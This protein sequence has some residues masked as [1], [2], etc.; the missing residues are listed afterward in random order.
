MYKIVG[1]RHPRNGGADVIVSGMPNL[2]AALVQGYGM[3]QQYDRLEV[4]DTASGAW[5][6]FP[7]EE[8]KRHADS[9]FVIAI[10]R[11]RAIHI[12]GALCEPDRELAKTMHMMKN[13]SHISYVDRRLA[14]V[15]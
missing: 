8:F 7:V 1:I 6:E 13:P 9:R 3:H 5:Y 15:A 4:I 12:D 10:V 14:G 11:D 2:A